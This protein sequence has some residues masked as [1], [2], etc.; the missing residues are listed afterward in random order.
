MIG[1]AL[2]GEPVFDGGDL[3]TAFFWV[4]VPCYLVWG[5]GL[6]VATYGYYGRTRKPCKGRG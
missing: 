6:A 2:Q 1:S 5:V 4:A 3:P